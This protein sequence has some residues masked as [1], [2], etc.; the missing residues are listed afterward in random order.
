[1]ILCGWRMK[2]NF[3][4]FSISNKWRH[5]SVNRNLNCQQYVCFKYILRLDELIWSINH[6]TLSYQSEPMKNPSFY[7][8]LRTVQRNSSNKKSSM[9]HF[10]KLIF[11][12]VPVSTPR[13]HDGTNSKSLTWPVFFL[14]TVYN[15]WEK[16]S[17]KLLSPFGVEKKSCVYN[18]SLRSVG[19]VIY[20]QTQLKITENE[21]LDK[22][23]LFDVTRIFLCA[24]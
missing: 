15:L 6:P 4:L 1:M 22:T 13:K 16:F 12:K 7:R 23:G 2:N 20:K 5:W 21:V 10:E 11:S 14:Q 24:P 18:E 9:N 19:F 17:S 3:R 8:H